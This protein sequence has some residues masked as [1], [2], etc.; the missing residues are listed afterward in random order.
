MGVFRF[1]KGCK[2]RKFEGE[3]CPATND[4]NRSPVSE[5]ESGGAERV[6]STSLSWTSASLWCVPRK[7]EILNLIFYQRGRQG[8]KPVLNFSWMQAGGGCLLKVFK[9]P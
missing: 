9:P 3:V 4:G 6:S 2:S 8:A 7:T 1:R 5:S